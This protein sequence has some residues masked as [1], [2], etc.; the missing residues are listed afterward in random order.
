M[1]I[2]LNDENYLQTVNQIKQEIAATRYKA[3]VQLNQTMMTLYHHI[4]QIINEHK[5]WGSKFVDNLATDI[6]MA[7]PDSRGFSPRNLRYMAKFAELYPTKAILQQPVAKIPWGQNVLLMNSG[8]ST[9]VYLWYAE[10][11]LENGWSR[12]VLAHQIDSKL[13]ERQVLAKKV[14][15]FE[16]RLPVPQSEM[17]K[18]TLK[19]PYMFDFIAMREDMVEKDIEDAMVDNVTELLLGK[20]QTISRLNFQPLR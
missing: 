14:N 2:M 4:G 16:Q 10:K 20:R 15:N 1:A 12:N 18:E 6:R 5:A 9:D 3:V 13:Y 11:A 19:D 7:Y 17:A 8:L